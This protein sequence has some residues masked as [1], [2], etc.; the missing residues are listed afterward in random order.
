[1]A[2]PSAVQAQVENA[3]RIQALIA[4][5]NTAAE[6]G[7]SPAA[8]APIEAE[9]QHTDAAPAA[10]PTPAAPA[11]P[12]DDAETWKQRFRSLQGVFNAEMPKLQR[13]NATLEDQV[14]ELTDKV[15]ALGTQ[16]PSQ[17]AAAT[18]KTLVTPADEVAFGPE[19]IDLIKRVAKDLIGDGSGSLA[20]DVASLKAELLAVRGQLGTVSERVVV[21]DQDRFLAAMTKLVPD[22]QAI[23]EQQ[24]WLD[25]LTDTDPMVG[26]PRQ[27]LL[28][29]ATNAK[30]SV[31][32]AA[33]FNAY[34]AAVTPQAAR[35]SVARNEQQR[36]V[37]PPRT[38]SAAPIP[39]GTD[40]IWTGKDIALAYD[41]I[42]MG[43]VDATAAAQ[44]EAQIN[45][46]MSEGRI[47]P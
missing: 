18:G 10:A 20:K 38:R 21:S 43:R 36:Q 13:A 26:K 5:G 8:Q 9:P 41:E 19:L 42:R 25:W 39:Q 3:E 17:E 32:V 33:F 1:M 31:R 6:G 30:D 15:A 29:E 28:I 11:V 35:Q 44:I 47:A 22:W 34:K 12:A 23:D 46:A 7:E 16:A 37:A 14:R 4:A 45:A 24:G 40:R 27:E 2:L